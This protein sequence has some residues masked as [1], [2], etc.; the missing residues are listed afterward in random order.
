[1]NKEEKQYFYHRFVDE[2]NISSID[3]NKKKNRYCV[4]SFS[5]LVFCLV[6]GS[7][8]TFTGY[9]FS[10]PFAIGMFVWT[11]IFII[12]ALYWFYEL[13]DLERKYNV[14]KKRS[15][16][17]IFFLPVFLI[18]VAMCISAIFTTKFTGFDNGAFK[19]NIN[20][21]FYFA[22]F[23]PLYFGYVIFLY[24]AFLKCFGKYVKKK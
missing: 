5:I 14:F 3:D 20:P 4:S 7:L 12:I 16:P 17:Y 22:L 11:V 9:N 15:Y 13:I 2:N 6:F 1:M 10:N 18:A 8:P 24:Y 19:V 23:L 21:I